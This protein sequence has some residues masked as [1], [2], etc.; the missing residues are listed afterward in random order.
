MRYPC[1]NRLALDSAI[2]HIRSEFEHSGFIEISTT[3]KRRS[4]D[5]NALFWVWCREIAKARDDGTDERDV[6]AEVKLLKAFSI[7][8]A[9]DPEFDELLAKTIDKWWP[10]KNMWEPAV[11][12]AKEIECTSRMSKGQMHELLEWM[13]LHF[14]Q[15]M[16]IRLESREA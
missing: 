14:W 6:A 16:Q 10:E 1:D 4:L 15:A 7:R 9:D 13:Q 2:V 12:L 11:M 8:R 3:G 5:S